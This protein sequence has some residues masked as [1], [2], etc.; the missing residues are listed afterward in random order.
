MRILNRSLL[1]LALVL[2]AWTSALVAYVWDRVAVLCRDARDTLVANP[3]FIPLLATAVRPIRR[4]WMAATALNGREVGGVRIP[5]FLGR[6]AV[7]M[8]GG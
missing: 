8:L 7:R 5:G 4:I 1:S 3:V 2:T 6:P